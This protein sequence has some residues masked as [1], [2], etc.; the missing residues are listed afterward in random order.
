MLAR[1]IQAARVC[2]GDIRHGAIARSKRLKI[3]DDHDMLP[4]TQTGHRAAA[5]R[6]RDAVGEMNP[7]QAQRRCPDAFQF[8]EL[9]ILRAVRTAGLRTWLGRHGFE[10]S[11]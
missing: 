7:R 6:K 4:G 8:D 2:P 11:P 1:I 9:E 3:L 10:W 5:E